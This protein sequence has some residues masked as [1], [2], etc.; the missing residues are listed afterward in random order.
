MS[1]AMELGKQKPR[2]N[3]RM[4]NMTDQQGP[5][6]VQVEN[7]SLEV[8]NG[9][10]LE[11]VSFTLEAGTVTALVSKPSEHAALLMKCIADI[12]SPTAGS[13]RVSAQGKTLPAEAVSIIRGPAKFPDRFRVGEL[14]TYLGL[15]LNDPEAR[16]RVEEQFGITHADNEFP[17]NLSPDDRQ[18]VRLACNFIGPPAVLLWE[19]LDRDLPLVKRQLVY[20]TIEQCR[21]RGAVVLFSC[22]DLAAAEALCDRV[23]VLNQG[24]LVAC[25]PPDELLPEG[26]KWMRIE[27]FAESQLDEKAL[28]ALD[29]VDRVARH[30]RR[31]DCYVENGFSSAGELMTFLQEKNVPVQDFRTYRFTLVD[32]VMEML[33]DEKDSKATG[34]AAQAG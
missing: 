18:M 4:G 27:V 5:I 31:Y 7:L 9:S 19:R 15:I 12:V 26:Q 21:E 6:S 20:R 34:E 28:L 13:V 30:G 11:D 16:K 33:A 17:E 32:A 3:Y 8:P 10:G 25:K 23:M 1:V 24:K 29:C 22:E 14:L 2:K